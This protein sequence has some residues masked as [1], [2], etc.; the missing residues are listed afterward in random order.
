MSEA[1]SMVGAQLTGILNE[2][3]ARDRKRQQEEAN[4]VPMPL[5]QTAEPDPAQGLMDPRSLINGLLMGGAP[6]GGKPVED[7]DDSTI[8]GTLDTLYGVVNTLKDSPLFDTSLNGVRGLRKHMLRMKMALNPSFKYQLQQ[9]DQ[10]FRFQTIINAANQI[11]QLED[12]LRLRNKDPLN[13]ELRKQLG[14]EIAGLYGKEFER[15]IRDRQI[16]EAVKSGDINE[17]QALKLRQMDLG[18]PD[19]DKRIRDALDLSNAFAKAAAADVDPGLMESILDSMGIK[20]DDRTKKDYEEAYKRAEERRSAEE[21]RKDA[22]SAK[23]PQRVDYQSKVFAAASAIQRLGGYEDIQ[24][25]NPNDP[26]KI[27]TRRAYMID[28]LDAVKMAAQK[29][30]RTI[31]D[32]DREWAIPLIESMSGDVSA[33]FSEELDSGVRQEILRE[34]ESR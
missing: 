26:S 16:D 13:D 20:F 14:G 1:S 29:V 15:V 2:R 4:G 24:K 25:P 22:K 5:A 9:K 3:L 12:Q 27:I 11:A 30:A 8:Q 7:L 31:P 19:Q 17:A 6:F 18:L 21:K 32:E 10:Q 28:G 34:L 33:K 23:T